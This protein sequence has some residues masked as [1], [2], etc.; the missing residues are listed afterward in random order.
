MVLRSPWLAMIL[1]PQIRSRE[2]ERWSLSSRWHATS[3]RFTRTASCE[4]PVDAPR[5]AQF[6]DKPTRLTGTESAKHAGPSHVAVNAMANR[7]SSVVHGHRV[8]LFFNL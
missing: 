4:L 7:N 2:A 6:V 8:R 1:A 5:A 3:E